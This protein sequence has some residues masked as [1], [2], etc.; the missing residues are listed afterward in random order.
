MGF[1]ERVGNTLKT[2][3]QSITA[4]KVAPL[5][6]LESPIILTRTS[7]PGGLRRKPTQTHKEQNGSRLGAVREAP[8]NRKWGHY[9]QDFWSVTDVPDL[10]L[11]TWFRSWWMI[12]HLRF[13]LNPGAAFSPNLTWTYWPKLSVNW[14]LMCLFCPWRDTGAAGGLFSLFPRETL[15]SAACIEYDNFKSEFKF[16]DERLFMPHASKMKSAEPL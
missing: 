11:I 10:G 8:K 14:G 1:L 15:P 4:E 2:G 7:C 13:T 3:C 6:V 12:K 5:G 16:I 9:F